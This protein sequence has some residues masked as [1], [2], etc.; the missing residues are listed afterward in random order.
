MCRIGD[1]VGCQT[2]KLLSFSEISQPR[3]CDLR[4]HFQVPGPAFD[5][6]DPVFLA[7]IA[8]AAYCYRQR[9]AVCLYVSHDCGPCRNG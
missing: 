7:R 8:Y 5:C 2:Y 9:G 6:T 4:S 3:P 1:S